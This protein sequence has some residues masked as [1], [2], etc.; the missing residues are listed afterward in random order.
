MVTC[1]REVCERGSRIALCERTASVKGEGERVEW[2]FICRQKKEA[3]EYKKKEKGK[4]MGR[5]ESR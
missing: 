2:N 4:K 5:K 3:F 1:H